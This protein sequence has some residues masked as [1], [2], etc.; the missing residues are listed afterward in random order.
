MPHGC[1]QRLVAFRHA[2]VELISLMPAVAPLLTEIKREYELTLDGALGGAG[3]DTL[4]GSLPADRHAGVATG[5]LHL[6]PLQ[7]LHPLQLPASYYEQRWRQAAA[8]LE[9]TRLQCSRLQ[10]L[11]TAL[12]RGCGDAI[13]RVPAVGSLEDKE[14]KKEQKEEPK[15]GAQHKRGRA[16][17]APGSDEVASS[18]TS[19]H[20]SSTCPRRAE[21]PETTTT[22]AALSE[23]LAC[24][25]EE[26]EAAVDL[27]LYRMDEHLGQL[28]LREQSAARLA[29]RTHRAML[30]ARMHLETVLEEGEK[31]GRDRAL[32]VLLRM[33]TQQ[34][35]MQ[36]KV[37][38]LLAPGWQASE[39]HAFVASL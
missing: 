2:F 28:E 8:E 10:R 38:Q 27:E 30:A 37:S 22:D 31:A 20:A 35:M 13:A 9:L 33:L 11:T 3:V 14:E 18:V 26:L 17:V 25:T 29:C 5:G 24:V 1:P 4:C 16:G 7:A 6:R 34:E 15:H 23:S 36:G 19:A 21:P 39:L 12:R 32:K